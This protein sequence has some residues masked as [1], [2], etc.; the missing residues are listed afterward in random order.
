MAK[1]IPQLHLI[2]VNRFWRK[3]D[4]SGGPEACWLWTGFVRENGYGIIGI[5][6][7]EYKAHRV[8]YFIE[9]GRIDNGRLVLHYC[10]V[11]A[12]VN[13][14][15]LFSGTPKDNSQDAVKK[16]RN[17]KLYGEQNGK[18]KLTRAAVLSIRRMCKRGGI[19]QKTIAKQFGVS[20][21]TVSYI[22]NGGR[23]GSFTGSENS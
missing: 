6:G 2:Q 13:P 4:R 20:E 19:Y 9:H 23:W 12:C 11:R 8:S 16:R 18:A 22:V 5:K 10:D 14:A 3:V 1:R 7:K 15:H 21:A 17:T